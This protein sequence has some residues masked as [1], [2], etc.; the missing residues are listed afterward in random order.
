MSEAERRRIRRENEEL[1]RQKR[2]AERERE[3]RLEEHRRAIASGEAE[4]RLQQQK[5]EAAEHRI[6]R[7][8]A[9]NIITAP[10]PK[11]ERLHLVLV[12]NSG[13]NRRIAQH[14]KR[15]AKYLLTNLEALDPDS[16]MAMMFFS[17]HCDGDKLRQDC[18]WVTPDEEGDQI[19]LASIDCIKN[20]NGGDEPEAIE[21]ILD[22][23]SKLNFSSVPSARRFVMSVTLSI[24]SRSSIRVS[25]RRWPSCRNSSSPIRLAYTSISSTCPRCQH[26][27]IAAASSETRFCSWSPEISGLRSSRVS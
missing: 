26:S 18:D 4:K 16:Q 11:A 14:L 20:A 17:D 13:S 9:R 23:A 24:A 7:S 25:T 27:S 6:D 22:M 5:R 10:S 1:E 2:E 12:D 21:C 8:K 3:K 19:L 15:S